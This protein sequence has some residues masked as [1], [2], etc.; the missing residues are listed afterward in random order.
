MRKEGIPVID[1]DGLGHMVLEPGGL[2][3]KAV[4]SKFGTKILSSDNKTIDR[5]ELGRLVF[6]DAKMRQKLESITHPAIAEL[7]RQGL[8]LIAQRDKKFAVYE[9]ALLV[10]TGIYK[11]MTALIVVSATLE[12]QLKRISARDNLTPKAAAARIASQLPLKEKTEV[13]DYIIE[14]DS[15]FEE[16]EGKVKKIITLLKKRFV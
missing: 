11:G 9:A 15:T 8:S 13:A 6:D 14:N 1:A 7:A 3:Y 5:Q 12:N 16:L 2:A 10:E 4:I